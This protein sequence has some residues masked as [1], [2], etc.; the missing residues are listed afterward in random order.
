MLTVLRGLV[1]SCCAGDIMET[2]LP[3]DFENVL[4]Q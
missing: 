4:L 2:V 1:I 3:K